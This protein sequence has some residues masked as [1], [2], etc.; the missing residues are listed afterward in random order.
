MDLLLKL[1]SAGVLN[2]RPVVDTSICLSDDEWM[3][4]YIHSQEQAVTGFFLDGIGLLPEES[5]PSLKLRLL[6][7]KVLLKLEDDNRKINQ[8]AHSFSK[9]YRSEGLNPLLFK[10][11][12]A[13][14]YYA[15]PLHRCCGDI[16]LV[17]WRQFDEALDVTERYEG[18]R[19]HE[20]RYDGYTIEL[21]SRAEFFRLR[22][23]D[24]R[25]EVFFDSWKEMYQTVNLQTTDGKTQAV[26]IPSE[27]MALCCMLLHVLRHTIES[28][29]GLK[30]VCDIMAILPYVKNVDGVIYS[31]DGTKLISAVTRI[32]GSFTVPKGV[33]I[34]GNN[35]FREQAKMTELILPEGVKSIGSQIFIGV[36]ISKLEIPSSVKTIDYAA[37]NSSKLKEIHIKK[38]QG[39]ISGSPWSLSIGE[40]GIF[41]E[42]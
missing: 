14:Y 30:Q 12:A 18:N 17:F 8:L 27:E 19:N 42:G 6:W 2:R 38:K 32:Q 36:P 10:G 40:R 4:L 29:I 15:N 37:F 5:K 21:H 35:P 28:G 22:R 24:R 34:I 1:V 11:G 7:G 23:L 9:I 31:K 41:W 13:A 33:T 20:F 3:N 26:V 16:D 39:T 25:A